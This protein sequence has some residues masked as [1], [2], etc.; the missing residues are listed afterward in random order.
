M[1]VDRRSLSEKHAKVSL[2]FW[3]LAKEALKRADVK[4]EYTFTVAELCFKA[5]EH[6]LTCYILA[7]TKHPPP[8]THETAGRAAKLLGREFHEGFLLLYDMYRRWSYRLRMGVERPEKPV[9][10]ASKR[11]RI[12]GLENN[13]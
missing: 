1:Y 10:I 5:V 8:E 4:G 2:A 7:K 6:S 13:S 9:N 12:L 11:L 3:E